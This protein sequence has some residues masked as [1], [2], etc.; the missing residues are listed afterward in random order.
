MCVCVGG[1][2]VF[3]LFFRADEYSDLRISSALRELHL[4]RSEFSSGMEGMKK[5]KRKKGATGCLQGEEDKGGADPLL[6]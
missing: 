6:S 3:F 2:G 4:L 5:R 1:G